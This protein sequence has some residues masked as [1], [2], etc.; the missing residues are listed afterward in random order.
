[1]RILSPLPMF[2][3]PVPPQLSP[4]YIP[5]QSILRGILGFMDVD[6]RDISLIN[7]RKEEVSPKQRARAEQ[8]VS[9]TLFEQ[10]TVSPASA[11]LL[12][13]WDN[14]QV[15]SIAGISP[16]T[17]FCT[18]M[19]RALR[20]QP[21]FISALWFC[22][23]HFDQSDAGGCIGERA[24]LASLIDQI[25]RQHA[26]QPWDPQNE[27]NFHLLQ[28]GHQSIDE[29]LTLLIWLIR[30][31]PQTLTVFFIIDSVYLFER[32][33]FWTDAQRVFLGILRL[34]IDVSAIVKVLFTSAPG[35]TMVRGAFE[36]EGLILS[37]DELPKLAW[38]PSDE[39][40]IREMG[41]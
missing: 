23:L 14:S 15:D 32:E 37:V 29:L 20:T 25:L 9:S 33:E 26:F 10:W 7:D 28:G 34:V 19:A 31:I 40:M 39:R 24:M 16:L 4:S 17:V 36:Q 6:L 18:T 11:K 41:I 1:M 13:E 30:R 27:I 3:W 8:I 12:V 2:S 21:R 5:D 35:T 22:G 38:A